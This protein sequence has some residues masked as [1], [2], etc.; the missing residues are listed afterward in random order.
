[1]N[2]LPPLATRDRIFDAVLV[3]SCGI[4][5][6]V[7]LALAAFATRDAFAALHADQTLGL[8]TIAELGL[9][10]VVAALCLFISRRRAEALGQS[11]AI[12][13]RHILYRQIARLPK[14][15]HDA[16]RVGALSLR[17]VG[18]LSAARLWFGRGLPDVLSATVIL[19]GAI[20]ILVALDPVLAFAGLVPLSVSLTLMVA[21]AWHLERRHRRLRGRRAGIAIAMIERVAIAPELDLMGRTNKELRALDE[22]G[23]ALRSVAVARRGRT[24]GLQS[25]LQVGLAFAG[26]AMLWTASHNEIAPATVAAS[27]SVIALVTLPMQDLGAAWDRY[28]SWRVAR[29]KAGGDCFRNRRSDASP[30]LHRG[31]PPSP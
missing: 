15:R 13:L 12:S 26:I 7:A 10:G 2:P 11:Y 14:S 16:R 28:C 3:V 27:L 24:V 22:K 1:M 4:V 9:A 25:V 23:T 20:A 29:E 18:D 8:R 21:T 5:Q 17:F 31:L 19:P 6:A 30:H